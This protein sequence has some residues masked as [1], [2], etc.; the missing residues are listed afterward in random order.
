MKHQT[1]C[2]A[3]LFASTLASAQSGQVP[4]NADPLKGMTE[5][6]DG[7]YARKTG[8]SESYYA[9]NAAGRMAIAD[10]M[11]QVNEKFRELYAVDGISLKEQILLTRSEEAQKVLRESA[12]G[13]RDFQ[14]GNCN[15][16]AYLVATAYSSDGVSASATAVNALDFGPATPTTNYAYARAGHYYNDAVT[17]GLTQASASAYSPSACMAEAYSIVVCPNGAFGAGPAYEFS[18]RP[19]IEYCY[20]E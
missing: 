17:T 10:R 15:N 11:Y 18:Y 2:I 8:N 13:T 5:V 9:T 4:V 16:G 3:L 1:I 6:S 12:E 14:T 20:I 7:L 19:G